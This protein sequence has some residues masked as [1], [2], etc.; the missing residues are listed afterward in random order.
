MPVSLPGYSKNINPQTFVREGLEEL[1]HTSKDKAQGHLAQLRNDLQTKTGV[2]RLLHTS[3]NNDKDMKFKNAGAFKSIF[4]D[5]HKL[6]Q[7]AE[8]IR[9]LLKN[10]G[11]SDAKVNEFDAYVQARGGQG[12]KA[13]KVLQF[14]D[15]MRT[16]TGASPAEALSK[17]GVDL[18]AVGRLLGAGAYGTAHIVQYR[19]EEF[20]YKQP[21]A[22]GQILAKLQ[23]ADASGDPI[24][25]P[26]Q[27]SK[28][29]D[30]EKSYQEY[31][32]SHSLKEPSPLEK[33]KNRQ[34]ESEYGNP[35]HDRSNSISSKDSSNSYL[36]NKSVDIDFKNFQMFI[37]NQGDADAGVVKRDS[38]DLE[39]EI[40]QE[41]EFAA[42]DNSKHHLRIEEESE[43]VSRRDPLANAARAPVPAGVKLAR[44]GM[45]NVARVK[46]LPQVITPTVLVVKE[47]ASDGSLSYHAVAGQK[48]LKDWAR[49][50]ATTSE[51]DVVGLLMPKAAGKTLRDSDDRMT[52]VSRAD[53]KPMASSALNLLKGLAS[54]G[55]I[56]GD[57]KP[58]NLIWDTKSKTLQ[59]IDNDSMKKVSK[60]NGSQVKADVKQGVT[61]MYLNPVG[62]HKEYSHGSNEQLGL[63][64]DLFAMGLTLLEA[65][66]HARGQAARSEKIIA[67]ITFNDQPD[68][69]AIYKKQFGNYDDGIKALMAEE[70]APGS[71]DAFARS[72]IIKSIEHEKGR[73]GLDENDN[74][75]LP[76]T[77]TFD[78]YDPNRA[79]NDQHLLAQLERDLALLT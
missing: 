23:L 56:H 19:G 57:I 54:H 76:R 72:C 41:P 9:D 22:G 32:S 30:G 50:Q 47:Q 15:A 61:P 78:R 17:F 60:Q 66:L 59:L 52:V 40:D 25:P 20:V 31:D 37:N 12:V 4:L 26:A 64:R 44:S 51:F 67:G 3:G 8:V 75:V 14:I 71:V 13:Q 2:V 6:Q 79:G 24:V 73:L 38:I 27:E 33:I 58:E 11:L 10:A 63:G 46:D 69:K 62:F 7:S 29:D 39:S 42:F 55:F 16:E 77:A 49:T 70:F 43:G 18:G 68:G 74:V 48:T 34:V 53:L 45:G 36:S 65:S 21:V 1:R 35:G 5:G 28:V